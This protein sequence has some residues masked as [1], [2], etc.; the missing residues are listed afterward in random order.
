MSKHGAESFLQRHWAK[1]DWFAGLCWPLSILTVLLSKIRYVLIHRRPIEIPIIVVGN[2]SVGGTGK[3]PMVIWL[4]ERLKE[5]GWRPGIVSRGYG[6]RRPIEGAWVEHDSSPRAMGDEPVLIAQRTQCPVRVDRNRWEAAYE[7]VAAG[8]CDII[9]SDDGL[10]HYRLPR[11]ME[12]VMIDGRKGLG[13]GLCL[14]AGPLREPLSRLKKADLV[15]RTFNGAVCETDELEGFF[16]YPDDLRPVLDGISRSAP[17]ESFKGQEI[18]AVAG[19]GNPERFFS[20]LEKSGIH[21]IRHAFP[22]HHQYRET[23]FA[24]AQDG[25]TVL[26]TEKDAVKCR[27]WAAENWWVVGVHGHLSQ[28]LDRMIMEGLEKF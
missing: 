8:A 22:D 4:S 10:Q 21:V 19:I 28:S 14:P 15:I 24:F 25:K 27:T 12:I 7:L 1:R 6:G 2:I 18:H 20:L 26:M 13:N 11:S 5:M 9:I 16:L 3:T 17:I 23:D